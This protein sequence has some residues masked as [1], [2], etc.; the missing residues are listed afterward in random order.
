M[1]CIWWDQ[2]DMVYYKWLKPGETI[3]AVYYKQQLMKLNQALKKKNIE[4][5]ILLHENARPHVVEPIKKYTLEPPYKRP[6][7]SGS[8]D[9]VLGCGA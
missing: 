7:Y 2:E 4:K 5:L 9:G 8:V 3:T 1:L 6:P